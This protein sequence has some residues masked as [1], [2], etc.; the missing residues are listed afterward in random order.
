[1]IVE[2]GILEEKENPIKEDPFADFEDFCGC[3]G[4]KYKD[5]SFSCQTRAQ[6]LVDK[7]SDSP[8]KAIWNLGMPV[9][10]DLN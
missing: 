3:G 7:Y 4:C 6:Y 1:M 9:T 2:A 10:L 5:G 8:S